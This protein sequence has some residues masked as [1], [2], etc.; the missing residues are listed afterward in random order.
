LG[1]DELSPQIPAN[2]R[3]DV[4]HAAF[5]LRVCEVAVMM[6]DCPELATVARDQWSSEQ[7]KALSE[8]D[9]LTA[10]AANRVAIVFTEAGDRPEVRRQM[11]DKSHRF[12]V[13]LRFT[14]EPATQLN[15]VELTADIDLEHHLEVV[16]RAG[17]ERRFDALEP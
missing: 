5:E 14:F 6:I 16:R 9:E 2:A 17:R 13:A 4:L 3:L 1:I 8:H 12:D 10:N 7:A 11:A 15:A